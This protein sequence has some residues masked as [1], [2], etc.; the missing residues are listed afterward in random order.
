MTYTLQGIY[1][2]DTKSII[3]P[4]TTETFD[5]QGNSTGLTDNLQEILATMPE[6]QDYQLL[7]EAEYAE[8]AKPTLEEV[9]LAKLNAINTAYSQAIKY[10]QAG[11]P[12]EEILSWDVQATEAQELLKNPEAAAVFIRQLATTKGVSVEVMR[13][14]ILENSANW[15]FVAGMLTAQRQMMEEAVLEAGTIEKIQ[16]VQIAFTV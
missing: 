5:E 14:R 1:T 3:W 10:V 13:D 16:A 8:L 2:P 6:G 7:S 9:R 4:I 12:L 11:Y 15:K